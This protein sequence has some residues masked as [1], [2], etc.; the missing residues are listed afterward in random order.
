MPVAGARISYCTF[1]TMISAIRSPSRTDAPSRASPAKITGDINHE[2]LVIEAGAFVQGL[3][4]HVK[5]PQVAEVPAVA[6]PAKPNLV[7]ADA[8][9][10]GDG[11]KPDV[12]PKKVTFISNFV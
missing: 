12:A 11:R 3:C 9:G 6:G 1:S 7:V 2:S 10:M 4:R 8:A 5:P